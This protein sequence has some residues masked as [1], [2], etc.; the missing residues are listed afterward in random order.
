M[1]HKLK[2]EKNQASTQLWSHLSSPI[3]IQ[4]SKQANKQKPPGDY[5]VQPRLKGWKPPSNSLVFSIKACGLWTH[6]SRLVPAH[7]CWVLRGL[8]DSGVGAGDGVCTWV[9][10]WLLWVKA[11]HLAPRGGA[12]QL[13]SLRVTKQPG[14][15]KTLGCSQTRVP[16]STATA[17]APMGIGRLYITMATLGS[18]PSP[19]NLV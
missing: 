7:L 6:W 4:A 11:G 19:Q 13:Q 2:A 1:S 3:R 16:V 14:A 15:G 8:G 5:F 17:L 10:E 18:T 12:G 9:Q